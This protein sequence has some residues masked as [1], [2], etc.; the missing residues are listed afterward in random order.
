MKSIILDTVTRIL[1]RVNRNVPFSSIQDM[2]DSY[3]LQVGNVTDGITIA[4]EY[5]II[6][7]VTVYTQIPPFVVICRR[8]EPWHCSVFSCTSVNYGIY[9]FI[10]C[11]FAWNRRRPQAKISMTRKSYYNTF[12]FLQNFYEFIRPLTLDLLCNLSR[13]TNFFHNI[14]SNAFSQNIRKTSSM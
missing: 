5:S 10:S 9:Q 4:K 12:Y 8:L 14:S 2:S 13:F 3:P 1:F 7:L 6:D 11:S